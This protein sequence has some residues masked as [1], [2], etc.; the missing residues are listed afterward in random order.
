MNK[1][2]AR[3]FKLRPAEVR[4][5]ANQ[6]LHAFA[7]RRGW[8]TLSRV[9]SDPAF[10]ELLE[11][12]HGIA[13]TQNILEHYQT[14]SAAKF[15][16]SFDDREAT[17][18]ELRRRWPQAERDILNCA[19]P[20]LSGSFDLLGLRGLSFGKDVDWHLEPLTT[21]R[22]PAI[23]WS[24][25]DE[26]DA[27][28]GGDKKITWELNR[29]QYFISL[30][31]AYWLTGD[32]QYARTLVS[33][34]ESWMAA[35]PPKV[36]INWASSLEIAFRS[37]S[38]LWAFQFFKRSASLS[39]PLLTQALKFLYL[40]ARHLETYLSTYF[41]PNTHLTGEALGLFYIGTLLQEFKEAERWR[42]TGKQILLDQLPIH[43][44]PDGV[45]FEQ[46]SYYHRY[47][48]D[49]Y[50]HFLILSGANNLNLPAQVGEKLQALLDHL[51]FITRPD[52]STPFFGD[53]DGGRL[54]PLYPRP[55]NDSRASLSNGAGLFGRSDYKFVARGAAAETLW[56]LGPN[57]L[58]SFD[59]VEESEPQRRSVAFEDGGYY[60]MRDGWSSDA[61]YLLFDC[62][63]HGTDNCG[64]AHA[65]ALSLELAVAGR[66]TLVDPGTFT[67]TGSRELRDWFRSS[68][69][70]NTLTIDDRSSSEPAGPFSWQSIAT[71]ALNNWIS[72]ERFDYV[73]G[74]HN[75][76]QRLADPV[77]H[78]RSILFLKHDY[79]V[80]RDRVRSKSEHRADVWFHFEPS[81]NPLIQ[82]SDSQV[83]F[84]GE[85][86]GDAGLDVYCFGNGQWRRKEAWVSHCYAER[87]AARAYAFSTRIMGNDEIVTF[88]LPQQLGKNWQVTEI[89]AL[90][91]RAFEVAHE[92]G[93]D[94]VMIRTAERVETARLASNFE[95]TWVRFSRDSSKLPEE[96]VILS[97]QDLELE[98]RKI[99]RSARFI[100]YLTA[101][102]QGDQFR[103][104]SDEGVL[105][106]SLSLSDLESL[107]TDSNRQA[108]S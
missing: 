86:E 100:N 14:R 62:G 75:G 93:L 18:A 37:I 73:A 2:V 13:S 91:G 54:L 56:L 35:N 10:L 108:S 65:D 95:W 34:L 53:D 26:L 104:E 58:R 42:E 101:S 25:L 68:L 70:H 28:S 33:H 89:E 21:K 3:I 15:F 46:S 39:S 27:E 4:V 84:A 50:T 47:T 99:L 66:T 63:P 29:H 30:G 24:R 43:V 88:L 59:E 87:A 77:A 78:D 52:G 36:G 49:I 103:V 38:W 55:A 23:H 32:E 107:F 79:W 41:S 7:E 82:T 40:N 51:M 97:G 19:T 94:I 80:M 57:A 60:V 9:P 17:I 11:P 90:G 1:T 69:A 61:N 16:A 105:D 8:S 106:L 6:A 72:R 67:Y 5:R 48:T 81:A 85:R 76:Y 44:R 64:H 45:Y 83:S 31:Q 22:T 71:C 96:F 20:L 98:G 92:N 12:E 74:Q 102:R